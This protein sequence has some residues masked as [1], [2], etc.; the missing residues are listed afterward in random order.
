MH[1]T[2]TSANRVR[3]VGAFFLLLSCASLSPA[4]QQKPDA[5]V[6]SWSSDGC[7]P[8]GSRHSSASQITREN[9]AQ[10]KVAWTFHTG[11]SQIQT[12]LIRKAAFESTPILFENKLF[13][14]SPYDQ[15]FALDP[16]TGEK[17]WQFDPH[18]DLTRNYSEVTSRGVSSWRDGKAKPGTPCALRIFLGTLDAR[19]RWPRKRSLSRTC[20]E[21][22]LQT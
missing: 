4:Q 9:V 22:L 20:G 18:V 17:I 14:T 7:D 19:S 10:L 3:L 12:N 8:G 2:R 13:L 16:A 1:A 11:A 21:N 6:G 15:V 5:V